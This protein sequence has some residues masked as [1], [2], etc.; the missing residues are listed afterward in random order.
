M[1]YYTTKEAA[2]LLGVTKRYITKL[3]ASKAISGAEKKG[4]RW[5]IPESFIVKNRKRNFSSG[6][7]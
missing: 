4:S 3:C 1:K 5:M 7:Y 2:E 6:V